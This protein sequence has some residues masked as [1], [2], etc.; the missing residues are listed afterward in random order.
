MLTCKQVSRA[1]AEEDY[2][3]MSPVKRAGVK[4]HVALC[5]VCGKY[6]RQVMTMQDM[7]RK[8]RGREDVGA[9][10]G[11]S[12]SSSDKDAIKQALRKK[13]GE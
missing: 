4:L 11:K 5:V 1:L 3:A 13:S 7:V 9:V 8:F 10:A 2:A 6:N 12:L